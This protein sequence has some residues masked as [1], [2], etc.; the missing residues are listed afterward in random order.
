MNP[1]LRDRARP[2][3]VANVGHRG[4]MGLRPENTLES[5]DLAFDLGAHM[6]EL[7]V[8]LSKDG[9]P[10]VIHDDTL[11]RTT[12]GGR[13]FVSDLTLAELRALDAGRWFVDGLERLPPPP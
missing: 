5:F 7:D 1:Y 12:T 4:A 13:A 2:V 11:A 3:R 10:V 6:V 8:H 9:H